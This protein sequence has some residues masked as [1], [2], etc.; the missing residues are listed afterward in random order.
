M[1]GVA[2]KERAETH[3]F[4]LLKSERLAFS[5]QLLKRDRG[6]ADSATPTGCCLWGLVLRVQGEQPG[7]ALGNETR[8]P[9]LLVCCPEG[10]RSLLLSSSPMPCPLCRCSPA[11]GLPRPW[12][13]EASGV[14]GAAVTV[15]AA[16]TP[17]AD[18]TGYTTH[19]RA[20]PGGLLSPVLG[21]G[22]CLPPCPHADNLMRLQKS[23]W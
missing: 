12:A 23:N 9:F 8:G 11:L 18:K 6:A 17:G 10:P 2:Q 15:N 21:G 1:P 20:S 14:R 4:Q 7:M 19:L 3:L 5:S 22:G 13:E 16:H